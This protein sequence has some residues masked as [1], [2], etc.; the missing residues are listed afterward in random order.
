MNS[1]IVQAWLH[2]VAMANHHPNTPSEGV[3]EDGIENFDLDQTPVQRNTGLGVEAV[4]LNTSTRSAS[5]FPAVLATR[6]VFSHQHSADNSQPD[7]TSQ[8]SSSP[9]KRFQKMASLRGLGVPVYFTQPAPGVMPADTMELREA[10]SAVEAKEALL[11]AVLRSHPDFQGDERIRRQT[12]LSDDDTCSAAD[13]DA[14]LQNHGRL[15]DIVDESRESA[16]VQRS[17]AAWNSH[18]HSN[19]LKH[20]TRHTQHLKFEDITSARIIP[21]FRPRLSSGKQ[22]SSAASNTSGCGPTAA[23]I[24]SVHKMVDFALVMQEP[25]E[26]QSINQTLYEPLRTRPA[27]IFIETMTVSGTKES[28]NVQLGIWI[29]A[30][31]QRMRPIMALAGAEEEKLLTLPVIQ[32]MDSAW[33][34]SFVVDEGTHI[35]I[36][37]DYIIGNTNSML[38]IYQLQA[39]MAALGAWVKDV[40][41]PWFTKLL[42]RAVENRG[43]PRAAGSSAF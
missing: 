40:F 14:V 24:T 39:S 6:P 17:E 31:R 21:A 41:E 25:W 37:D 23:L 32:V 34:V 16:D 9:S 7:D 4:A 35:C 12:W 3:D 33:S 2:D 20:V 10:L 42:T 11:P 19:L 28:A 26:N 1:V 36:I 5:S 13:R 27:P 38:G 18:V 29:A 8:R 22:A 30:W 43:N 15:R